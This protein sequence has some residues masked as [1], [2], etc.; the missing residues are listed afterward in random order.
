[1][2]SATVLKEFLGL[3]ALAMT[4]WVWTVFGYAAIGG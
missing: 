4:L 1:M 2:L 3:T